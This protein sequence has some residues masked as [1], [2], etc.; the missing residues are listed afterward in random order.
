[1]VLGRLDN[2]MEINAFRIFPY[3][4]YKYKLNQWFKDLNLRHDSIKLLEEN[5]GKK[6]LG[7]YHS[8]IF[9][10][11]FLKAKNKKQK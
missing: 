1:M 5:I 7:I 3:T 4:L 2:H 10:D 8:N 11:Q 6:F 9:L